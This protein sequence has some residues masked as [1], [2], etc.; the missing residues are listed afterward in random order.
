MK[1]SHQTSRETI[2]FLTFA[3]LFGATVRIYPLLQTSFPIFD[4]GM[5]HTMIRDLQS[6]HF[7]LPDL[8]TY[9][10]SGIPFAYPPLAFYI[11]GF[12]NSALHLP[13]ISIIK[14]QPVVTNLLV[15][16]FFFLFTR[17]IVGSDEK[18]ALVTLIFALT[19]NSYWW[20]IV[21]G[22]LS[23][24]LGALFFILTTLFAEKMYCTRKTGWIIATVFSGSIT[25][26]SHPE[27]ALQ[28]IFVISLFWFFRGR[29]KQGFILLVLTGLGI[30]MV[31]S[32]WWVHV[33]QQHGYDVFLQASQAT[34]SRWLFFTTPLTIGLHV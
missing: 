27:W 28:A 34:E 8:T 15:L 26:L 25:M 16:P 21:G 33:M 1:S 10:Q 5:F 31:T 9:N 17:S 3:F 24:A 22:G 11:S 12:I 29:D 18:A 13:L 7:A 32:P 14:W 4:G 23:R 2:L 6:S 20:Q 19:P 30:I